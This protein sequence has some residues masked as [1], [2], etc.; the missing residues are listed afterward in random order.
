MNNSVDNDS[1]IK[2]FSETLGSMDN[3]SCT[4]DMFSPRQTTTT[5]DFIDSIL[6]FQTNFASYNLKKN[7]IIYRIG[8]WI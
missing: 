2:L 8:T 7:C 6:K 3:F 5:N 4:I 1:T